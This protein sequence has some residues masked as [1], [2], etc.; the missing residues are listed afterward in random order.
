VEDERGS[1]R[2]GGGDLAGVQEDGW[3]LVGSGGVGGLAKIRVWGTVGTGERSGAGGE[4]ERRRMGLGLGRPLSLAY[5]LARVANGPTVVS[6][7]GRATRRAEALAQAR[8]STCHGPTRARFP[9][10]SDQAELPCLGPTGCMHIF[11][12]DA[13]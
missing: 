10:C 7:P 13:R 4:G 3:Y 12:L 9:P 6:G 1:C 8:P 5:I 11:T 2:S